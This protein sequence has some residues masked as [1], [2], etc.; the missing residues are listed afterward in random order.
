MVGILVGSAGY[1]CG[2]WWWGCLVGEVRLKTI[3]D[4]VLSI[5]PAVLKAGCGGV[6]WVVKV[7]VVLGTHADHSSCTES[8]SASPSNSRLVTLYAVP[9]NRLAMMH[10]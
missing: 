9:S 2:C 1:F 10:L 4:A 6:W 3:E 7:E 8:K 5:S